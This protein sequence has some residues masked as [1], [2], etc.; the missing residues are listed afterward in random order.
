MNVLVGLGS[1][2]R[3]LVQLFHQKGKVVVDSHPL[4]GKL[5]VG[6][7]VEGFVLGLIIQQFDQLS[8]NLRGLLEVEGWGLPVL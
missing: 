7:V 4:S 8:G 6:L 1:K 2:G 3:S 5:K